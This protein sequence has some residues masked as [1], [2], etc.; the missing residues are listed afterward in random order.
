[1]SERRWFSSN[2]VIWHFSPE[3]KAVYTVDPGE[4][5]TVETQD[6]LGGQVRPG[7]VEKPK[8]ERANPATGPIAV[9]N[10][11]PGQVLAIDILAM[12]LATAGFLTSAGGS[13]QFF[14]QV[15]AVI[16]F[17]PGIR[18]PIRPMIGTIGVAPATATFSNSEVGDHGGNLDTRDVAP[19]A[20]L[21]LTVQVPDGLLALG[22]VHS[23]QADG[24]SSGQGVETA[25]AVT[26]RVRVLPQGLSP[27]PYLLRHGELMVIVS[28]ATLDQAA[29]EAVEESAQLLVRHSDLDY[30]AARRLIG[31]IGDVR[32]SQIVNPQKTVRVALPVAA[33]PWTVPLPL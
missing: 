8:I 13:P 6:A 23:L 19:G 9:R 32:V 18:L 15:G 21:Y 12:D 11:R 24:E 1:M 4:V 31:L 28:A 29:K 14:D 22:D 27:R 5:F 10:A 7:M 2:E 25:C 30:T 33:V 3:A 16:P 26:L 20:T 17:A